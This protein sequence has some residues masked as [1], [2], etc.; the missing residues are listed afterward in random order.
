M[1]SA[2]VGRDLRS[3]KGLRTYVTTVCLFGGI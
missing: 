3:S 1:T 2:L